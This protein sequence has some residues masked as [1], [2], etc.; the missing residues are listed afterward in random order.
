MTFVLLQAAYCIHE[1][2]VISTLGN[3]LDCKRSLIFLVSHS[4]SRVFVHN[5]TFSLPARSY[6]ERRKTVRSL[7]ICIAFALLQPTNADVFPVVGSHHPK[8][9]NLFTDTLFLFI[10]KTV[11]RVYENKNREGLIDDL[12]NLE[13][14]YM[15]GRR[16]QKAEQLLAGIMCRNFG[17]CGYR[18]E[19]ELKIKGYPLNEPPPFLFSLSL[20]LGSSQRGKFTQ[21]EIFQ[22]LESS[23]LSARCQDDPPSRI[24]LPLC[25]QPLKGVF[26]ALRSQNSS[27]KGKK[28]VKR[29]EK[30]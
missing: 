17:P 6:E 10:L 11:E 23:Y 7:A 1:N 18:V 20:V 24:F 28:T 19:K 21:Q 14:V 5:F 15:E 12:R 26:R 3:L 22:A 2:A 8:R 16:S 29:L 4:S 9:I 25:K 30:N 27:R 13:T